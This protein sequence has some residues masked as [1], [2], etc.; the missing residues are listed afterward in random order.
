M[1]TKHLLIVDDE[2]DMRFILNAGLRGLGYEIS[3]AE[4]GEQCLEK[5]AQKKPDLILLDIMLPALNG[6]QVCQELKKNPRFNDIPILLMSAKSEEEDKAK[7]KEAG[8]SGYITKPFDM[9]DMAQEIRRFL[10]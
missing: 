8:A 10:G 5:V 2:E 9:S 7:G 6:Y 4:N 1:G 3:T